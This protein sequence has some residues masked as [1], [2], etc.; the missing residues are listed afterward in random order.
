V[1]QKGD[2]VAGL[3][4]KEGR[5]YLGCTDSTILMFLPLRNYGKRRYVFRGLS[6]WMLA[7]Y[8]LGI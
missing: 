5:T 1:K 4:I 8:E 7:A 2:Y 6:D 3:T